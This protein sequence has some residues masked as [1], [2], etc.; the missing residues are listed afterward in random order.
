MSA[1]HPLR[2]FSAGVTRGNMEDMLQAF[3]DW[4]AGRFEKRRILAVASTALVIVLTVG[5]L[6]C[7]MILWV[8]PA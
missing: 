5:A 1:F 4:W 2:T 3:M 8:R 6:A 7:A